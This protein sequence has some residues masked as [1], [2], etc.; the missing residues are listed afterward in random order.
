MIQEEHL[1]L[2]RELLV[3]GGTVVATVADQG[4]IEMFFSAVSSDLL[5]NMIA[6]FYSCKRHFER[7]LGMT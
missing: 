3:P 2:T 7:S 6:I 5:R 1:L 4:R